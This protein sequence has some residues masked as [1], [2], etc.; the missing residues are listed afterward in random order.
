MDPE[1]R[2]ILDEN[3][4]DLLDIDV[5]LL[6]PYLLENRIFTAVMLEDIRNAA[7]LFEE[8]PSRGPKAFMK[9]IKVLKKANY[10]KEAN[11]LENALLP[12]KF[13]A[14]SL[15][16]CYDISSV[17]LGYCLIINNVKFDVSYLED[18]EGSNV[19]ADALSKIFRK[20]GYD[21]VSEVNLPAA[22]MWNILKEFSKRDFTDVHSCIVFILSHGTS[23]DNLD[24]IYGTDGV[25]IPKMDIINLFNNETCESLIDKP[26]IFFFQACRGNDSDGGVPVGFE[27]KPRESTDS[28]SVKLTG[29]IYPTWSD[30]YVVHSTLPRLVSVRDHDNG[31]WFCQDL[32][33]VLTQYYRTL[34]LETM[35][36]KVNS[37]MFLRLSNYWKKQ[38]LHSE[39][40][41]LRKKIMFN[42]KGK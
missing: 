21:I 14:I 24:Y 8:L 12:E 13:Q 22:K 35:I 4:K 16:D 11:K 3:S 23:M 7:D 2:R 17:P 29:D 5:D 27:K 37:K 20:I 9:F 10:F 18:R 32:I 15:S 40:F 34:D 39:G 30:V 6:K 26:R 42:C 19:D 33:E 36:H 1:H 25:Y 38:V 28:K 41:G 31:T